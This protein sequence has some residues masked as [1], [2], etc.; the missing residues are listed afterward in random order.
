MFQFFT[1]LKVDWMGLRKPLVF[2]SVLVL[3][4]GLVSAVGRQMSEGGTD[5]FNL[6]VDFKG[7]SVLTVKFRQKPTA[8]EIR[9]ALNSVG[10]TEAVIQDSTD[11][12]DEV[13]IK[14]PIVEGAEIPAAEP[15]AATPANV[16]SE[17]TPAATPNAEAET[18][19]TTQVELGRA[20]VIKGLSKFGPETKPT[21]ELDQDENAAF[22]IVGTDSVGPIAG[23]QLRN[24]AI[25]ATL[26]GM[27]GMLLFIAFRYDWT[28]SAGAVV[29]VFHDV[30][31]T[32][33]FFS[34]FQWEVSLTVLAAM[35][36]LV[37]FSVNDSIV[38]FDRIRENVTLHRGEPLY[39]LVNLSINQT[40]S[41]TIVTN[42]LT[43]LAVLA[44]VLFGGEVLRGFSLALFVGAIAGTYSTIAIASPIAI[45]WQGKIGRA[46]M[47]DVHSKTTKSEKLASASRSSVTRRPVTR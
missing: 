19:G 40:M 37:G 29:A 3:L 2:I 28:Y 18:V 45:W 36:T 27:I 9:S 5:A 20:M 7:G 13:L 1:D 41:R 6:G 15:E 12:D 10:I 17:E 26:M 25:I 44:L 47:K 39:K 8:D 43:F 22:K 42:G 16:S 24:A 35:L 4:A 32:L 46:E 11:K 31:V 30:L 34:I 38:I 14:I 33:A 23:E 21:L